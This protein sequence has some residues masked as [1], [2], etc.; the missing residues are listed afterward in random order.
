MPVYY[1]YIITGYVLFSDTVAKFETMSGSSATLF[2]LMNGDIILEAYDEIVA[3]NPTAGPPFIY[4]FIIIFIYGVVS[5]FI[6]LTGEAFDFARRLVLSRTGRDESRVRIEEEELY[7]RIVGHVGDAAEFRS[8]RDIESSPQTLTSGGCLL[9]HESHAAA[10]STGH[11]PSLSG[12]Q[13]VVD[14]PDAVELVQSP[15]VTA[16]DGPPSQATATKGKANGSRGV[17]V[18]TES[19]DDH[20]A[21]ESVAT[22]KLLQHMM[23]TPHTHSLTDF[24]MYEQ[25]N[26]SESGLQLS[27]SSDARLE[28][29]SELDA[30]YDYDCGT[31]TCDV[32]ILNG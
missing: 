17:E 24:G 27:F 13:H 11:R 5:I 1:T 23:W 29:A 12:D 30:E 16:S 15:L 32:A 28:C 2:A 26:T 6:A 14:G 18:S 20:T 21:M 25:L 19:R 8:L 10:S 31:D 9:R 7:C 4:S 22:P 3:L